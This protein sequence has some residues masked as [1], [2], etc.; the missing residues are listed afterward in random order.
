MVTHPYFIIKCDSSSFIS[1]GMVKNIWCFGSWLIFHLNR[2]EE[3]VEKCKYV[4]MLLHEGHWHIIS[5]KKLHVTNRSPPLSMTLQLTSHSC[6]SEQ[7]LSDCQ[8]NVL[9]YILLYFI[10]SHCVANT[11]GSKIF[12]IYLF[13]ILLDIIWFIA[14]IQ[15]NLLVILSFFFYNHI[16][17]R[18]ILF[19]VWN[20]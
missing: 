1:P 2:N 20:I 12:A 17:T 10:I 7:A 4:S 8:Q 9:L 14:M 13:I 19:A 6:Y 3:D 18:V 5:W 15:Y 11:F 16:N